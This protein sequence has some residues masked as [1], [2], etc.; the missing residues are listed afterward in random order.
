MPLRLFKSAGGVGAIADDVNGAG[1]AI[2]DDVTFNG[3]TGEV[4]E[5]GMFL[6]NADPIKQY[7][8]I[9][10]SLVDN[11]PTLQVTNFRLALTQSGLSTAVD[12][13]PVS[14]PNIPAAN[15]SPVDVAL[16]IR[17]TIAVATVVGS[18]TG[19]KFKTSSIELP[20]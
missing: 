10:F 19:I 3:S 13:A 6:R 4:R 16:F 14:V 9:I 15:P 8:G 11:D 5:V 12:G 17:C 18:F 1:A 2:F 20:A 7:Q